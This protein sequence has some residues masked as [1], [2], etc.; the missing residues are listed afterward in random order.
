ME[1]GEEFLAFIVRH[2]C[3]QEG[4]SGEGLE[5]AQG[6]VKVMH[7]FIIIFADIGFIISSII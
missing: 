5:V 1:V 3:R 6:E 2:K 7:Y 4:V